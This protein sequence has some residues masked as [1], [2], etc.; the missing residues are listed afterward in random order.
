VADREIADDEGRA[1]ALA[2]DGL[3]GVLERGD[4][5]RRSPVPIISS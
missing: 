1:G 5:A 4:E 3:S 2:G